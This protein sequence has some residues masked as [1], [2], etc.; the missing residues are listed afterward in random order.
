MT[1]SEQSYESVKPASFTTVSTSCTSC[2]R[3]QVKSRNHGKTHI[4]QHQI[5]YLKHPVITVVRKR[6]QELNY[7]QELAFQSK[8]ITTTETSR[9]GCQDRWIKKVKLLHFKAHR[10]TSGYNQDS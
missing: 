1:T 6:G 2:R 10:I 7:G 5:K 4:F 3:S 9:I 8:Q